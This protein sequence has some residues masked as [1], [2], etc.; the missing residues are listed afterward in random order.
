MDHGV[1]RHQSHGAVI[2]K[3]VIFA[4]T[5]NSLYDSEK[6]SRLVDKGNVPLTSR[7]LVQ[8][9]IEPS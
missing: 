8:N 7:P 1:S 4:T 3:H 2:F 6:G 9:S 5:A